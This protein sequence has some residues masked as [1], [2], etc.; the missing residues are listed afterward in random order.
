MIEGFAQIQL[1]LF[2]SSSIEVVFHDGCLQSILNFYQR[3]KMTQI[4]KSLFRGG[5]GA[6]GGQLYVYSKTFLLSF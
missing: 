2:I 4:D 1:Q 6:G 5:G 3:Q